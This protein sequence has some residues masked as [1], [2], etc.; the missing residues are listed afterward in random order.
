MWKNKFVQVFIVSTL[1]KME[2]VFFVFLIL[3]IRP[4]LGG[5]H[6]DLHAKSKNK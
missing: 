3:P 5:K 2:L 1:K 6:K 4:F